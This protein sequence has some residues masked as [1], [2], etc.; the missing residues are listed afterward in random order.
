M[1]SRRLLTAVVTATALLGAV[2]ACSSP[3]DPV[4]LVSVAEAPA[5]LDDP[6]VTVIDVR[7]PAEFAAGHLGD[8]VNID[9]DS[10][11]FAEAITALPADGD[12]LVYCQSGNRS[13][14][15]T[16]QMAELGFTTVYD[17]DGGIAAWQAAGEPVVTD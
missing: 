12:Y 15:A 16:S 9:V 14:R 4:Q 7:T 8:A 11:R 10:G 17:L 13:G 1:R 2:T 6:D 3:D 5:V